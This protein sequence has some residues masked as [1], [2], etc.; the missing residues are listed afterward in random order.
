[1]VTR[2]ADVH[3]SALDA[4]DAGGTRRI[5]KGPRP[6]TP[7]D[8]VPRLIGL[9]LPVAAAQRLVEEYAEQRVIDA[10]DALDEVDADRRILD[11]VGW[12]APAPLA[13]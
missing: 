12:V 7:H 2:G 3:A 11:P 9:G 5:R 8:A 10:L 1:M 13:P 4:G 6:V